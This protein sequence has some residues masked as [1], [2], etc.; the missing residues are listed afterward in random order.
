MDTALIRLSKPV[1]QHG[2]RVTRFMGDGF[3]AVFGLPLAH[4]NDADIAVLAGLGI[5]EVSTPTAAFHPLS[6]GAGRISYCPG[7]AQK[8]D[9]LCR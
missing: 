5:I 3:K 4:E 1:E 9:G 8:G 2:G 7:T 6:A